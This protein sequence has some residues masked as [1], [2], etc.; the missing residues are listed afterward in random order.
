MSPPTL[1]PDPLDLDIFRELYGA[2]TGALSGMDPRLNATRIARELKVGRARVAGRL[3]AWSDSGFLA[4]LDVWLNP[5]LFGYQGG[6]YNVRVADP[7]VKPSVIARLGLVEGAVS[8]M[9]FLGEWV[10]F[11]V[12]V[13]DPTGFERV[14]E[15]VRGFTG[16]REVEPAMPWPSVAPKRALTPL[17]LRVVRALRE[18]PTA[19][20]TEIAR[21]VGVSTRTMTRRY[22]EL[23]G[24]WATWF[25]PVFDF[26]SIS[27]PIVS[28][29]VTLGPGAA[30][31]AIVRRVRA[32]Y[33]LTEQVGGI[34]QG[35]PAILAFFA[36]LPSAAHL[37]ELARLIAAQPGVA[38]VETNVMVRMHTF[39]GWFDRQ[40]EALERAARATRS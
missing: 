25:V 22:A 9:E 27:D 5:A 10:T 11:G 15:L 40:L 12:V 31:A 8:S 1:R 4:R 30:P 24:D 14:R 17:D 37:E 2:E 16:V 39:P 32:R 23:V 21:R 6:F 38:G 36:I 18:R 26:R 20:L 35:P 33:P 29:L 3:K 7:H 34:E 13:P 19:S 28:V